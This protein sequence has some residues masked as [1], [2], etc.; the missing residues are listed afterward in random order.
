MRNFWQLPCPNDKFC[1]IGEIAA[2]Y[3]WRWIGF[4]P[5]DNI[6]YFKTKFQQLLLNAENVVMGARNPN[7]GIIFHMLATSRKPPQIK[8]VHL[9]RSGW[10]IPNAFV[11]AYYNKKITSYKRAYSYSASFWQRIFVWLKPE[12][13]IQG[14][15]FRRF[16]LASFWLFPLTIPSTWQ[17]SISF[18]FG[19]CVRPSVV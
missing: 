16:S 19:A 4:R 11:N 5:S 1:G 17:F 13:V 8:R 2:R 6:Q 10:F 14:F 12:S 3:V 7:G 9:I 15:S 18:P